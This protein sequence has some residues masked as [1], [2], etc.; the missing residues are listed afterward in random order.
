MV[1][2]LAE[3]HNDRVTVAPN[4]MLHR[5]I[6]F[7]PSRTLRLLIAGRKAESWTFSKSIKASHLDERHRRTR[8]L[9]LLQLDGQRHGRRFSF[10]DGSLPHLQALFLFHVRL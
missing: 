3:Q 9:G 2:C 5:L 4:V 10:V 1:Q 7:I 8:L 6:Q